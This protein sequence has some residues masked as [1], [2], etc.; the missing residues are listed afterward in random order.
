RS[1]VGTA[2]RRHGKPL[3][4]ARSVG[5]RAPRHLRPGYTR[6]HPATVLT[7]LSFP[8]ANCATTPLPSL[9]GRVSAKTSRSPSTALQLPSS[10]PFL[11]ANANSSPSPSSPPW[12]RDLVGLCQNFG[13]T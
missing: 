3:P 5:T 12:L 1:L 6:L 9:S 11:P 10:S 7:C 4:R 2:E 13:I 8:C